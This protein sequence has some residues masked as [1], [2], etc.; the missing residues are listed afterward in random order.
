MFEWDHQKN[1]ANQIKH[2]ISFE[3]AIGIFENP[4]LTKRD[5]RRDYGEERF[6]SLGILSDVAILVVA[7]TDRA[8]NIRIIS[9][10]RANHT[11]KVRYYEYLKKTSERD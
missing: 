9:A 4:L 1:K 7:H 11:E 3:E 2:G 6:I 10:R 8:G 5:D